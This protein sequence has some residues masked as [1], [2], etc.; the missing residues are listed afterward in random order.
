MRWRVSWG[1]TA[2]LDSDFMLYTYTMSAGPSAVYTAG[3]L[4][5]Y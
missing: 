3:A 2:E 1:V 4:A 5:G